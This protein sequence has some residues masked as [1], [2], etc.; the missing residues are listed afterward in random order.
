MDE[1]TQ[2]IL[3]EQILESLRKENYLCYATL[4]LLVYDYGQC[5][6]HKARGCIMLTNRSVISFD[7]EVGNCIQL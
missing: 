4:A 5:R 3:T 1:S 2:A 6:C 7:R